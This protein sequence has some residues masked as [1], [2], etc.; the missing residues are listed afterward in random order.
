MATGGCRAGG[1]PIPFDL[2]F[3]GS[4]FRPAAGGDAFGY[5]EP[6]AR[7]LKA[8][9]DHTTDDYDEVETFGFT[10]RLSWDLGW[11]EMISV[12]AYHELDK[13][14]SLD[15]DSGPAPQFIVMNRSESQWFSQE[16]RFEGETDLFR[17][18][19][20]FYFLDVEID[21]AQGLADS[22]GGLNVF[23]VFFGNGPGGA[24]IFPRG[25]TQSVEST[26]NSELDTTSYSVFGQVDFDIND[27]LSLTTGL[28]VILEEKDFD[29]R[30][31]FYDNID[32]RT[33]D[34]LL[35]GG[36]QPLAPNVAL[37]QVPAF[38]DSFSDTLFSAKVQLNYTPNDDLLV[39]GGV[40][41]GV[42]AGS[43]NAPLLTNL[44]E[45]QF[46]YA[47]EVL[48]AYEIGFKS[49]LFDGR[50]RLNGSVYYYDY[51][52][53]Q[54]FQFIGTSGAVV[55]ADAQYVG[56]EFELQANPMENMDFIFGVGWIDATVE[57]IAVADGVPG[58]A[59]P[60]LRDVT[61]TFTPEIQVSG[62]LRYT[63]PSL[64]MGGDFAL[65]ADFNH[66]GE[67]F[68][69]I[70][71]FESHTMEA[72][73]VGNIRGSWYSADGHWEV[74]AFLNNIADER[75]QTIGFELSSVSGSNEETI[76]APRWWGI[77]ARYNWGGDL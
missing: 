44:R 31:D 54:A 34:G 4:A 62:I 65:Q 47:E 11:A 29:Y 58:V 40:N 71:N 36:Q 16:L 43:Y 8:N 49:S 1:L 53:Y 5:V 48:Y 32:D 39:Y 73:T 76:G 37:F 67:A 13:R 6:D 66:A 74:G 10:G 25:P 61:P 72:Y 75:Y 21:Y 22:I 70:N 9:T 45:D 15:V 41:R 77:T 55:N 17:W 33:T 60:V 68:H 12:T 28:R 63:W 69:N 20:G 42:K 50:A 27:K 51:K 24:N 59:D 46:E 23:S 19:G 56:M 52:D 3:G 57:G 2:N 30:V 18:I 35:F 26:L 14:Q 38:S 64:I 7:D